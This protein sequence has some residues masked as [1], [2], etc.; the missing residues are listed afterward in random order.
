[1][2]FKMNVLN[3]HCQSGLDIVEVTI[4]L[5]IPSTE[6]VSRWKKEFDAFVLMA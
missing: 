3:C 1:M 2:N 6:I 4:K 5:N